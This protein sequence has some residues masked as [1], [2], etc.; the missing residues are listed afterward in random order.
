MTRVLIPRRLRLAF[1]WS[2]AF[3]LLLALRFENDYRNR[4]EHLPKLAD[5]HGN[6]ASL[7][8]AMSGLDSYERAQQIRRFG[9]ASFGAGLLFCA[10]IVITKSRTEE[11]KA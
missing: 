1:I 8:V 9:F 5:E 6:T 7:D 10:C 3:T 11:P 2:A 4:L